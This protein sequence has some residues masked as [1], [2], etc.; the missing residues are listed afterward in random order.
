MLASW[1]DINHTLVTIPVGSG[2]AM[3]WIE[4][5]GTLF[6]LLCIYLASREKPLNFLFGLINVSLFAVIFFQIQLY[7]LLLLQLFFF[8]ANVYGWYAWTHPAGQQG[9]PLRIRWL[10]RQKLLLTLTVMLV[11]IVLL[12]CYIDPVFLALA[13]TCVALLNLLGANLPQPSLQPD[14]YP[15]WDA[16]V[17][18]LSVTAQILMTRKYVENWLLWVLVNL[19]SIGIYATQGVYAMAIEY[20]I[21]LFIAANGAR[22]WTISAHRH[23]SRP[24]FANRP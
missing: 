20:A 6:G 16:A 13:R 22:E 2:Y 21:L 17:T 19:I 4:A 15:F 9:Q 5:L 18:V 23:G 1:F 10:S 24:G 7:G 3:S 8:C 12:G 14:P 11:A